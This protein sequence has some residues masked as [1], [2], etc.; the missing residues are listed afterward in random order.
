MNARETNSS[1]G[2]AAGILFAALPLVPIHSASAAYDV[3]L[4]AG[5]AR[6]IV[7]TVMSNEEM[8]GFKR[9][10]Y[11]Y[12]SKERSDRTGGHLWMEKVVETNAGKVRFLLAEDGKPLS[13][14]R[15]GQER[16]RLAAIVADPDAFVKKSQTVK[17]D[18]AHAR[19][20]L[21][22]A[23]R[24][25]LFDTPR[26][27]GGFLRIDYR[28]NPD[29]TTQSIEERVLHAMSGSMLIDSQ[30][31]RLHHIE[32]RLPEDVSIGFG[33]LATIHAGSSFSTT[34]DRLGEPDWKTTQV[35]TAIN[36]RAIFFKSIA[37]NEHAEHSD[38]VRVPNDLTVV[39]AI[40]LAE[41]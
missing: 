7:A 4:Q 39:Q 41:Q 24:A 14:D 9:D 36:G 27:E 30:A 40:A 21:Q 18:E 33:L 1:I 25:F 3:P 23:P 22:L 29:Y 8:A 13:P 28:P 26:G 17:D 16:G 32:G 20:L 37:R 6:Q 31:M 2:F 19:K 5:S 38:F 11:A 35:D 12:I 15:I 34:R 10:H